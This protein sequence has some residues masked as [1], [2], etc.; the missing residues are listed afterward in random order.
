MTHDMI[1]F[2]RRQE[3]ASPRE[4]RNGKLHALTALCALGLAAAAHA[5]TT[6]ESADVVGQGLG[7]AVV[8]ADGASLRRSDNGL[9]V[10][11]RM[12][13]P[14]P[15]SYMYPGPSMFQPEGAYPGQPEAYSFWVFVFNT[16]QDCAESACTIA[17]F[18]AGVGTGGAFNAGGH[19]VGGPNLQL[20]GH[21]TLNSTPFLG[22][23]ILNPTTAEVHLAVA[24]HG[25][26]QPAVL[27][28]QITTPIGTPAHWWLALFLID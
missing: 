6:S 15:G 13:T 10:S 21:L 25:A 26:L 5:Q 19:I 20:S 2:Q 18:F 9:T 12:P 27:P 22:S 16:P 24:P 3:R 23:P 8:A 28:E 11:L 14:S 1:A 17:E 7:G 4:G